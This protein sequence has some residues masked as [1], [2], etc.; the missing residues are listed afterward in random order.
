MEF[1]T[2]AKRRRRRA[3][4]LAHEREEYFRLMDYGLSSKEACKLGNVL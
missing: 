1:E 3:R 4:K 2:R